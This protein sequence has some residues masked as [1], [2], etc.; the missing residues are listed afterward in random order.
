MAVHVAV[1][2]SDDYPTC[3][4]LSSSPR[5]TLFILPRFSACSVNASFS[6]AYLCLTT[7]DVAFILISLEVGEDG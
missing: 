4:I 1:S 6:R 7:N 3:I 5:F 2:L